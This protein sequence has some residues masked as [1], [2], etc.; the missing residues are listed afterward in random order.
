MDKGW[1]TPSEQPTARAPLPGVSPGTGSAP[2]AG[3]VKYTTSHTRGS[4]DVAIDV[5]EARI[6]R[7]RKGTLTAG[8][9]IQEDLQRSGFRFKA[10]MLTV[11]YAKADTWKADHMSKLT[12]HMRTFLARRGHKLRGVW[13]AELQKRGAVHYH[14]VVWLPKG[15]TFPKPDKQGWWPHGMTN[16]QWARKA[17]GYLVKYASKMEKEH[18]FPKGCRISGA[19]G[20]DR[21]QRMERR[22]WRMPRYIREHWPNWCSDIT[23]A[24]GGGFLSRL[25]GEWMPALYSYVSRSSGIVTI[26]RL[27]SPEWDRVLAGR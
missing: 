18:R 5:A 21:S 12:N 14:F 3:L 17:V 15:I 23:R 9:L 1:V 24:D 8:R 22:W 26:R 4:E 19:S 27:E 10:A 13:V 16:W 6:K 2:Q 7:M 25:T 11:T 20:L